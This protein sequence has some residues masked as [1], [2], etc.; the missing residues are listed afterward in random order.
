MEITAVYGGTISF[1]PP[2]PSL[3]ESGVV[4]Y[5]TAVSE[6]SATPVPPLT[7]G[8]VLTSFNLNQLSIDFN[9]HNKSVLRINTIA[10]PKPVPPSIGAF[11]AGTFT[12]AVSVRDLK[13]FPIS[14]L[15]DGVTEFN[16]SVIEFDDGLSVSYIE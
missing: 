5:L 6:V 4:T 3:I 12:F 11:L 1:I 10:L 16:S 8:Y 7:L 9:S 15:G 2:T 13:Q 14:T